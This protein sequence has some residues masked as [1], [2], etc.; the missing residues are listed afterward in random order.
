MNILLG[1]I[2]R[3]FQT[4]E[5]YRFESPAAL[6]LGV[7]FLVWTTILAQAWWGH[8]V[9]FVFLAVFLTFIC[10]MGHLAYV[11]LIDWVMQLFAQKSR[12]M[13]VAAWL[14]L[15]YLPVSLGISISLLAGSVPFVG[16]LVAPLNLALLV[17]SSVLAVRVMRVQYQV[18]IGIS[19]LLLS[20][21]MIVASVTVTL[22]IVSMFMAMV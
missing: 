22:M 16:W 2:L 8:L 9:F 1:L 6:A 18:G 17:W 12:F 14:A 4:I 11:G 10:L 21:P 3:P 13:N 7:M 5:D 15:C 19:L 20:L